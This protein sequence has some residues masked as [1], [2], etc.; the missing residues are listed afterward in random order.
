MFL[1]RGRLI[2]AIIG[3]GMV[4]R[5]IYEELIDLDRVCEYRTAVHILT[6]ALFIVVAFGT[7]ATSPEQP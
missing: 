6:F 7:V 4:L 1:R 2:G 3:M 5:L